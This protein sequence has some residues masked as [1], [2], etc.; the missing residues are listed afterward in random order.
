MFDLI[1]LDID[2]FLPEDTIEVVFFL[3]YAFVILFWV[4]IDINE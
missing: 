2:A 3:P 4:D 1:S